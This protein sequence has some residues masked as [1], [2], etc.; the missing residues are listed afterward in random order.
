MPVNH[1]SEVERV[2]QQLAAAMAARPRD[3]AACV[4]GPYA[5]GHTRTSDQ[6]TGLSA[7][8]TSARSPRPRSLFCLVNTLLDLDAYPWP[9]FPELYHERWTLETAIGDVGP[10]TNALVGDRCI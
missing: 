7:S 3:N 10:P 6:R 5:H 8:T 9:T 1:L 2:E 4:A